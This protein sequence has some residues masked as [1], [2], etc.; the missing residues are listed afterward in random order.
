DPSFDSALPR[1]VG[2]RMHGLFFNSVA[3][4]GSGPGAPGSVIVPMRLFLLRA[5]SGLAAPGPLALPRRSTGHWVQ[6]ARRLATAALRELVEVAKVEQHAP[7][8][9]VERDA[10][11]SDEPAREA[12]RAPRPVFGHL[13]ERHE[14]A[15]HQSRANRS[16]RSA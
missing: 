5:R 4:N 10:P 6:A 7:A 11:L 3:R 14:L 15:R 2:R 16:S 12:D 9:L 1:I 13:E 8:D